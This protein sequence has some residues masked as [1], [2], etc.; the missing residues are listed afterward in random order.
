MQLVITFCRKRRKH[1]VFIIRSYMRE[2]IW[3][4]LQLENI[5]CRPDLMKAAQRLEE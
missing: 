2:G 5:R 1:I 3:H 4:V